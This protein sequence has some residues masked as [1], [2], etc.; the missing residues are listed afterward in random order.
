MTSQ[1]DS[2]LEV[3]RSLVRAAGGSDQRVHSDVETVD[4]DWRVPAHFSQDQLAK[5]NELAASLAEGISGALGGH[6]GKQVAFEAEPAAQYFRLGLDEVL[7]GTSDFRTVLGAG[8]E[9]SGVML[10]D[11]KAAVGWV[12]RLLGAEAKDDRELS[13]LEA[14]LLADTAAVL[15]EATSEALREAGG[16][17]IGLIGSPSKDPIELPGGDDAEYCT[18]FFKTDASSEQAEVRLAIFCGL[19]DPIAGADANDPSDSPQ[20]ADSR[21][22]MLEHFARVPLTAAAMVGRA[23]LTVRELMSLEPGDVILLPKRLNDPIEL[24]VGGTVISSGR[25]VVSSGRSAVE[26]SGVLAAPRSG[27][28]GGD[29]EDHGQEKGTEG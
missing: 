22:I 12:T 7:S 13:G 16:E 25:A 19:L 4:Y 20:A 23:E 26:I 9:P 27:T 21:S 14:D 11:A 15:I 5:L 2:D 6:L 1:R 24:C 10:L 17:G 3:L 29:G 18:F 28:G 8:E